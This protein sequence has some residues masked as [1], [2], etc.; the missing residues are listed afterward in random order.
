MAQGH[1]ACALWLLGYPHRALAQSQEVLTLAQEVAHPFSLAGAQLL[2][3]W[4]HQ[5]RQEAQATHDRAVNSTTLAT[6]QGFAIYVTWG[7][8][9]QGWALTRQEQR[10]TGL[11]KM[12]EGIE[13]ATATGAAAWS[14]YFRALLA[15]AY[16][17][18]G[19][20]E[21]GLRVL[22]DA[23]A[24]VTRTGEGF[25][26]AELY[27]LAGVLHLTSPAATQAEAEGNI[28]HALTIARRQGARSLELRA[29]ISLSRLWQ[30]QGKRAEAHELLAPIYGWFTEGFDTK[31]LQEAKALL[32]ALQ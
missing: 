32:E 5:F 24:L 13:A 15:E 18:A 30:Q 25:Y 2:L 27:R 7:T 23:Q 17:A 3:S 21:E 16:G 31:D 4:L 22:A 20:A 11:A 12:R 28:T 6:Q 14:P 26:E 1:R 8:T 19:Q 29:A 9:M 10:A